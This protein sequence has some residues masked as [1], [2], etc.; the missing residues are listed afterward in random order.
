MTQLKHSGIYDILDDMLQHHPVDNLNVEIID[1]YY[2][3][4]TIC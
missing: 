1:T 2:F 3:R 4:C